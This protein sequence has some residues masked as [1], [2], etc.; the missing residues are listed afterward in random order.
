MYTNNKNC[1]YIHRTTLNRILTL[2]QPCHKQNMPLF[3]T[4]WKSHFPDQRCPT[5]G[6][7][8]ESQKKLT[9]FQHIQSGKVKS[10]TPSRDSLTQIHSTENRHKTENY[11]IG[12]ICKGYLVKDKK[13]KLNY[14]YSLVTS[15]TTGGKLIWCFVSTVVLSHV[16]G[17]LSTWLWLC[18]DAHTC[19]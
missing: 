8:G 18:M 6:G 19:A 12:T 17:G 10:G 11:L 3:N 16:G 14:E 5:G 7:D 15:L 4:R 1:S 13:A 2:H 9:H